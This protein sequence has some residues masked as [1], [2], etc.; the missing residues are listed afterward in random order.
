MVLQNPTVDTAV[1]EVARGGILREGLGYDRND[2]AVVTNVTGD[3]LGLGGIDTLGQL[4]N[5]KGVVVEAVPR[6]GTAVLN[7]DDPLVVPDGPPLRRPRRPVLDGQGARARRATTASTGT[8][9]AATRRSA[10]RTRPRA[11]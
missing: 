5:V 10:S 9:A 6:S 11:S 2:V 4:A 1:F 3:H 7:A 8:P